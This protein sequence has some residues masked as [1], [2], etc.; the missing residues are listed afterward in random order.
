MKIAHGTLVMVAD[1]EKMM[2]FRNEGDEKYP[3]LETLIHEQNASAASHERGSDQL[4][5]S[6]SSVG[7]GR[8]GYS[9][10]DRHQQREDRFATRAVEVLERAAGRFKNQLVV[11]AAPRFLGELRKRLSR[12]ASSRIAAEIPKDLVHHVTD[13]IVQAIA[14]HHS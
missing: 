14:A 2:M 7:S 13:D 5:R 1:G 9:Q 10:T 6:F 8:S 4:G 11:V 3:V 12:K